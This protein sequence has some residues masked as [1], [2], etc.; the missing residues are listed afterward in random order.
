[1]PL[2][3]NTFGVIG[4]NENHSRQWK[5]INIRPQQIHALHSEFLY[6]TAVSSLQFRFIAHT[7]SWKLVFETHFT[8][9]LPIYHY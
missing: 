8:W 9:S 5:T 3:T 7:H 4:E 6:V 2:I 1:M